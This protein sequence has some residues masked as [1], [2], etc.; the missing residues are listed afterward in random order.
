MR[1]PRGNVCLTLVG[2]F[3]PSG[4]HIGTGIET[5]KNAYAR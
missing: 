4:L 3:I 2:H 5:E 1:A